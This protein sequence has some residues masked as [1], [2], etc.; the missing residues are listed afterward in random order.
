MLPDEPTNE[1][2]QQPQDSTVQNAQPQPVTPPTSDA[3]GSD[4]TEVSAPADAAPS[5]DQPASTD[6]AA[7]VA[8]QSTDPVVTPA[9]P[10]S[11]PP[12]AAGT[13]L[14]ATPADDSLAGPAGPASS[15]DDTQTDASADEGTN[16]DG[17]D[18]PSH[19]E[20]HVG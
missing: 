16:G 6:D 3:S 14:S 2:S 12:E 11:T 4:G 19:G 8:T 15:P 13:D 20:V 18:E 5:F 7:P 9:E 17:T 10:V 1:D